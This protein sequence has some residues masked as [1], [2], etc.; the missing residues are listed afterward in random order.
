MTKIGKE[1]CM[2]GH[3]SCKDWWLTGIG[4]FVQGSGFT[5]DEADRIIMA[6]SARNTVAPSVVSAMYDEVLTR[7]EE[8]AI[9][10]SKWPGHAAQEARYAEKRRTL[11]E[12]FAD[13]YAASYLFPV[14]G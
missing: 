2:C 9:D 6:L 4:K 7:F 8:A 12:V 3:T 5:E 1:K 14:G 13:V 10:R 11:V